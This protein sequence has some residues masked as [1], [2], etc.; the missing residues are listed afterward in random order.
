LTDRASGWAEHR[1]IDHTAEVELRIEA[2]SPEAVLREALA[3]VA[4]LLGEPNRRRETV[5]ERIALTAVDRPAL[6]AAWVEELA[7]LAETRGLVCERVEALE[8]GEDSLRAKVELRPGE[9]AHLVK[10]V[11][12]HGLRFE[13]EGERWVAAAVLDV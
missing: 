8:A 10:G 9:A 6:L 5:S 2:G 1:W 3:A 13:R 7:F 4:E 11:T 12:Y